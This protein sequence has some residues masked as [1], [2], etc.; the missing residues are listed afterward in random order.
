MNNRCAFIFALLT[1]LTVSPQFL[2]L[3]H[4]HDT[5]NIFFFQTRLCN[6]AENYS[7][8]KVNSYEFMSSNVLIHFIFFLILMVRYVVGSFD[9]RPQLSGPRFVSSCGS[10]LLGDR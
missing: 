3:G 6:K 2:L 4:L 5:E 10:L 1:K 7:L 9:P 8:F